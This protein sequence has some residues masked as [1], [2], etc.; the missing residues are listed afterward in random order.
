M[1]FFGHG[2]GSLMGLNASFY[3][4]YICVC[5]EGGLL[6]R[7]HEPEQVLCEACGAFRTTLQ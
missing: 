2:R 7:A 1:S 5:S 4:V 6:A 3:A